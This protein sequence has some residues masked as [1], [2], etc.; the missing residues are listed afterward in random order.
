MDGWDKERV[1]GSAPPDPAYTYV[2]QGDIAQYWTIAKRYA[3]SD[4]TFAS[5]LDGSFVAHQYT[6]A[7][8]SSAA[9]DFPVSLWGC[10]GTGG[11]T[12]ATLTPQRKHGPTI[13]P[14]FTNPTIA[15][16]ADAKGV[17]WRFYAGSI[18]G[19]GGIW[20]SYQADQAIYNGPDWKADVINP[21]SK[22]LNDVAG[23]TL[24]AI[25]WISP[26][27]ETSDHPG[28]NETQGPAWIASVVN[29]I[30]ES[31][32]WNSTAIFILW[33]DWGGFFDPVKPVFEDYDGLG[34]RVPLIVVSPY[35]KRGGVTH[36]QYETVSVLRFIEDN[37][38]LG[39]LAAA[40]VRAND[41][42]S[43][44]LAFDYAM[45]P[46]AFKKIGGSKPAAYWM[47]LDRR[48]R[49]PANVLGDD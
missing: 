47:E 38:G 31:K 27:F 11:D 25:T 16:E 14:C 34:F 19:D 39:R 44:P 18:I 5:N 2:N 41:P 40:D 4:N 15:S 36:V 30:G 12:I 24:A 1:L 22:F 7:A 21:P 6:V 42:A 37:F 29:A 26:T 9:V 20:S 17:S 32:F 28:M 13:A 46:R 33:D 43:D 48:P 3:L 23:G 45:K 35:T 8:Y 49:A 10:E